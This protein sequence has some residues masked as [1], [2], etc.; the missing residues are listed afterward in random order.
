MLQIYFLVS[1]NDFALNHDKSLQIYFFCLQQKTK[2]KKKKQQKKKQQKNK[3]KQ[4]KN[5]I[6][7]VVE[8]TLGG[9]SVEVSVHLFGLRLLS[10]IASLCCHVMLLNLYW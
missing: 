5:D 2:K 7:K 9:S 4:K 10:I 6:M 3:K 1:A 8:S